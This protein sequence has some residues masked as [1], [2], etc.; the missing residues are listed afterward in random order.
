MLVMQLEYALLDPQVRSD[1]A[2]LDALLTDDFFEVGASGRSF[3]KEEVLSRL[4]TEPVATF[5]PSA[6]QAHALTADVI[7]VTYACEHVRLGH[8]VR[9]LRSSLWIR[10]SSGWRMRYHQ[11][12]LAET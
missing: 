11:G 7:L 9:S 8:A 1:L 3:G 12:T 5:A 4:P 6:M 2:R 10:D